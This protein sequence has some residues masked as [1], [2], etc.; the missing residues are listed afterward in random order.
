MRIEVQVEAPA[1]AGAR[2]ER[3]ALSPAAREAIQQALQ[4]MPQSELRSALQRLARR[5]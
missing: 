5:R 1:A 4:A 3:K 2:R